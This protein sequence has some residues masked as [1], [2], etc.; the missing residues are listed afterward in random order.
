MN[1]D[2]RIVARIESLQPEL[3]R[4]RAE[5]DELNLQAMAD[6]KAADAKKAEA[7]AKAETDKQAAVDNLVAWLVDGNGPEHLQRAAKDEYDVVGGTLQWLA[8]SLR[9][10]LAPMHVTIIRSGTK[11]YD[12]YCWDDRK[13]P[14]AKA[15]EVLDAVRAAVEQLAH[16]TSVKV[17]VDRIQYAEFEPEDNDKQEFTAVIVAVQHPAAALRFVVV[18]CES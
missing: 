18:N 13:S 10:E 2:P 8:E 15:F 4:R 16:P 12:A 11:T 5:C 3:L 1:Q 9:D 7:A 6:R 14:S 17:T